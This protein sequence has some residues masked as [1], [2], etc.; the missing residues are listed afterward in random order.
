MTTQTE[1]QLEADLITQLQGMKYARVKIKD[2][3]AMLA[4][5]KQQLEIHN[6]NITLTKTEFELILN[7]LNTGTVVERA[8]ILRD[9][10][11]LKRDA[12]NGKPAETI[13]IS[14]LNCEEWCRN[15][16]QVTNQITIEGKRKNRYD[17]T[18]LINGLPLVQIELK[19]RGSELKVAFHQINRYQHESYD[20]GAGLFQYVQLFIISNGVNTKY[21]ANNKSQSFQQTFYWTDQENN[22]ISDLS[23]FADTFLR[24]CHLAKMITRYI[25]ITAINVLKVLRPYQVY[26]TEALV[27]RVK[28]SNKNAYIWHTTGSGK[29]LTSFKASQIITNLP[30]VYKVVFVVD[31]KDLDYQTAKEFNEFAKGS[32]DSTTNTNNLIKQL[33]DDTTTL[34]VTTIQK[35]NNAII[36]ERYLEKIKHLQEQK[37]VFIFDECHRSQFGETHRNIKK[38]FQNAQMFGFTGTPI[39]TDNAFG[40]REH[41][42][43]TAS[44]FDE[45]LH[46]YVIIDAIKDENVLRFAVEYVGKTK[47]EEVQ[48]KKRQKKSA[49]NLDIA[50]EEIDTKEALESPIRLAKI[51]DYI[52]THH[53]QKTKAPDF[54]AMFCVSN[55]ETLIKYPIC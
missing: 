49:T 33:N 9:K 34:I 40:T 46:K 39:L 25:V 13:Y 21:F 7:H 2:Q 36:K 6:G 23:E 4:N 22:R 53:A 43:T 48:P 12:E 11:A 24:T 3:A 45:C 55:I 5:L 29:T 17:V 30:Q 52:L 47:Q 26:A 18:I 10:Y 8:K 14:F 19:K 35:L 27:E 41:Q 28:N 31:R 1:A 51:T 42:Q 15:E 32:V 20:A 44:L 37:F 50:I 54:T 16:F 38:F